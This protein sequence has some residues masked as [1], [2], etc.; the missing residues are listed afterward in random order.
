MVYTQ[1]QHTGYLGRFPITSSRRI[2]EASKHT[3]RTWAWDGNHSGEPRNHLRKYRVWHKWNQSGQKDTWF[4]LNSITERQLEKVH[5][6]CEPKENIKMISEG[7]LWHTRL[8]HA[9]LQCLEQLQKSEE[10]LEEG[11]FDWEVS[12]FEI[13]ILAKMENLPFRDKRSRATRHSQGKISSLLCLLTI[14]P[15]TLEHIV[16]NTKMKLENV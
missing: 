5:V 13:C 7:M 16:S 3:R 15:D 14:T 2:R 1:P 4:K 11:K 10:K 12:E 9:L 8:G 6:D